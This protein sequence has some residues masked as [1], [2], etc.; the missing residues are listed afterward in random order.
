[1]V[2]FV[3]LVL[4]FL[5]AL[6]AC[7]VLMSVSVRDAPD[8][9]RKLQPVPVPTA[10]GAGIIASV[11]LSLLALAA[12]AG[13]DIPA[14]LTAIALTKPYGGWLLL[15]LGAAVVGLAD[16][17]FGLPAVVKF[18]VLGG[19]CAAAATQS[20]A[21]DIAVPW[22]G[23]V[24]VDDGALPLWMMAGL[25]LWFFVFINGANFMDGAD[26]LAFGSLAIMLVGI[27]V[28]L[29]TVYLPLIGL[30]G[31]SVWT[32][33]LVPVLTVSA[34]AGFLVWNL[35]G[36]LYGGDT[37]ALTLG[38]LFAVMGAHTAGHVG[39]W[40]VAILSLP[41]LVDVVMTVL[42]RLLKG[43]NI[44]RAHREHA[45]QLF[46]RRG[47]SP[48]RVAVLWWGFSLACM[49]AAATILWQ[50]PLLPG[51]GLVLFASLLMVG[52]TLWLWQRLALRTKRE[53]PHA[54]AGTV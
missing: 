2:W 35:Q 12:L 34:I 17:V 9:A 24:I 20:A 7:R 49:L 41:F 22:L 15:V 43:D 47:A 53:D 30:V 50:E 51:Y 45:Y 33:L 42:Y 26:G 18:L 8:G 38:A 54:V 44:I 4:P 11:M 31:Q 46:I 52:V 14:S 21:V 1:M 40:Y 10:G 29:G 25:A 48:A 19:L 37:G 27:T 5:L 13:I 23:T 39:I 16:D 32:V 3:V 36:K 28:A 6:T